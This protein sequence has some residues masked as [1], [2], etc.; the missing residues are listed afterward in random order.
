MGIRAL[1]AAALATLNISSIWAES[2][3][4]FLEG[5]WAVVQ[6]QTS[7]SRVPIVGSVVSTTTSVLHVRM[8]QT[9]KNIEVSS[10]PCAVQIK[11]EIDT[12]RTIIPQA[13][14]DSIGTTKAIARVEEINGKWVYD[15]A[16]SVA[17]TGAVLDNNWRDPLPNS[18]DDRR[19]L[20]ADSDDRPGVTVHI[21]GLIDGSIFLVQRSW[22][23]LR[24]TLDKDNQISGTVRWNTEQK[25][26]EA[27]SMFLKSEPETRP[28]PDE[29][30]SRFVARK[31]PT[32]TQ[33]SEIVKTPR[34]NKL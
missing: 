29:Q 32:G 12:V 30:K 17:V 25:V 3:P 26:L 33:C 31:I 10:T 14:L 4:P 24:G 28:H 9:G 2:K 20:D 6:V 22:T 11:S 5:E 19:V 15:Q 8:R 34:L 7:Q 1:V 16:P 21:R 27:T 13:F 18:V 23:A